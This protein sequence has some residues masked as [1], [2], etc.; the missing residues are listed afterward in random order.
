MDT[1]RHTLKLSGIKHEIMNEAWKYECFI[2][3]D[4]FIIDL[5]W[6]WQGENDTCDCLKNQ[7]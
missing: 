4:D 1:S 7:F 2:W 6:N 5:V 3:F